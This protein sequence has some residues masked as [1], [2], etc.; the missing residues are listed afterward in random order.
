MLT[1]TGPVTSKQ[2]GVTRTGDEVDAHAFEVV[3]RIVE[4]LDLKLA[5]I[6]RTRHQH[7]ECRGRVPR[8]LPQLRLQRICREAI[9]FI[10]STARIQSIFPCAT[11][12]KGCQT[13]LPY[14]SCPL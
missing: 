4:R 2:V 12:V 11:S 14:P 13:Y 5:S 3:I 7:G 8:I 10:G 6:A 9:G 1:D